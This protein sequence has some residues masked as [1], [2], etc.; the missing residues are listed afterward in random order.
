SSEEF[1]RPGEVHNGDTFTFDGDTLA[2]ASDDKPL[3][4]FVRLSPKE[5]PAQM[6]WRPADKAEGR[7]HPGIYK[8]DGDKLPLCGVSRSDADD[9]K[10]RRT[11]FRTQKGGEKG[12]AAG[13]VLPV[14]E[15]KKK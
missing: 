8:L 10:D 7:S 13:E 4:Y 15:R 2:H 6:D 14:L 3:R 5:K 1:G 9:P 11:E 12:G